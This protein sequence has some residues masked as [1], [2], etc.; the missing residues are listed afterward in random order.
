MTTTLP[1][2]ADQVPQERVKEY[3]IWSTADRFVD[4]GESV[5]LALLQE[6]KSRDEINGPLSRDEFIQMVREQRIDEATIVWEVWDGS[7]VWPTMRAEKLTL[8]REA[9]RTVISTPKSSRSE[10]V[11]DTVDELLAE[12]AEDVVSSV[13]EEIR[14]EYPI[15]KPSLLSRLPLIGWFLAFLGWRPQVSASVTMP[16]E[17]TSATE[18]ESREPPS[19]PSG[20]TA[21]NKTV[22]TA[23]PSLTEVE[24]DVEA[25]T[26]ATD[27]TTSSSEVF[28]GLSL[29]CLEDANTEN[30]EVAPSL[31]RASFQKSAPEHFHVE[32]NLATDTK[33]E[34]LPLGA[35]VKSA[36]AN[37][38][39]YFDA[40]N[41]QSL[42]QDERNRADK[43]RVVDQLMLALI[44]ACRMAISP[45]RGV[46]TLAVKTIESERTLVTG[47]S[48]QRLETLLRRGFTHPI[49]W[50]VITG[51]VFV[52]GLFVVISMQPDRPDELDQYAVRK[53][54]E[55]HEA[56]QAVRATRPDEKAWAEF[57]QSLT[58]ELA[59][60]KEALQK[61]MN[62]NRVVKEG[63]YLAMEFRL[64]RILKEGRLTPS[65][66]EAEFANRI[67]DTERR[68]ESAKH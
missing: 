35:D 33:P 11:S 26:T 61:D 16:T 31:L 68:I 41:A 5:T 46:F 14:V 55:A 62:T 24:T 8:F 54:K 25:S 4:D 40:K 56:I 52:A 15:A 59:D 18:S 66:V 30:H 60:L 65:P 1:H 3:Y 58:S 19:R 42:V 50:G 7:L 39:D 34:E 47:E 2:P 12:N 57:S 28:G 43:P 64:P 10:V 9:H 13:L 48:F 67:R 22:I 23:A 49:T 6:W 37:A 45:F 21:S 29:D 27:S 36:I 44:S 17:S 32:H 51:G 63:L 20:M 53:L 38:L